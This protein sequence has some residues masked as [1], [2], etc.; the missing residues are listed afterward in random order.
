MRWK[1]SCVAVKNKRGQIKIFDFGQEKV[2]KDFD[3][4]ARSMGFKTLTGWKK[5]AA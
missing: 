4:W 2:A 1:R 5:G 3:T